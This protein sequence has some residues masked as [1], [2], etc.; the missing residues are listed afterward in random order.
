MNEFAFA[1]GMPQ[2]RGKIKVCP[3]DFY[4][5]EELGFELTGEGEHLFLQIE[6]KSLTT[7]EMVKEIARKLDINFKLISYA[8]LK[9]K[10]AQARQWFSIHLPGQ[11]DPCL[12]H[13]ASE[14]YQVLQT[15][16]HN[17]KLKI[18]SLKGNHFRIK[19]SDFHCNQSDI[20]YR[21][22]NIIK[23]GVPNYYGLQRFGNHFSNL[24]N[25]QALLFENKK[26]KNR[27]LRGLYYSAARSFLFNQILNQRVL[28]NCW[29]KPVKGDLMMLA[30]TNSVFKP[31]EIN[32]E[33]MQRVLI[34]DIYPAAPL[35][36]EGEN[37]VTDDALFMESSALN[38]WEKWCEKLELHQLKKTYRATVLLPKQF[39]FEKDTFSFSLPKGAFATSVLREIL[40][41]ESS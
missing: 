22:D 26:I 21:I 39:S 4:V 34:H 11:S 24:N 16:R 2:S 32:E 1:Y 20:E 41:L 7:E 33:I 35:W 29:N 25:A 8:G 31:D 9:D 40:M 27:Y 28:Q 14:Q 15:M 19:I 36:G 5:E 12:N 17:K 10:F 13:L 18:G 37:R 6:K 38:P 23:S 3:E 30:G